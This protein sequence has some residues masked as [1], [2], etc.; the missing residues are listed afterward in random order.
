MVVHA[1][2]PL[3]ETRVQREAQALIARGFEVDV[4]CLRYPGEPPNDVHDGVNVYRVPVR[5]HNSAGMFRQLLE[6]LSF[7]FLASLKLA[8]LHFRRRY[9]VIQVHN[10]PDFL[11]FAS[12]IPK[13]AGARLILDLHDLMPEFYA[14][15]FHKTMDSWQLRLVRWQERVSCRFADHVI[16]VS[17]HWRKTLILRGVAPQKCSVVMNVAD[18]A[19][20]HL[21]EDDADSLPQDG[22]LRMVYHGIIVERYGLDLALQAIDKVRH[23]IPGIHLTIIGAGTFRRSIAQM[24]E[25]LDLSSHVRLEGFRPAE[26]LPSIIRTANLGIVPYRNDIFTDTLVPT[27]L[28]EYAALGM[29]AIAA[30]TTAIQSLFQGTMVEF[31]E[32]GDVEDLVRCM[33]L[34]HR[35]PERLAALAR[36]SQ[37]FN[38]RYNWQKTSSQYVDLVEQLASQGTRTTK[39]V[40]SR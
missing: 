26:K 7:F 25:E 10:L 35:V 40:V 31:F 19:V 8:Y 22:E 33:R 21:P 14:A 36:A 6:Y 4:I 39:R 16:T 32:P 20:F 23:D 11:I 37:E 13:L 5:R 1:Y 17:E 30:R 3:G 24:V 29:P 34:L 15:R 38:Q 27:K 18:P 28:M 2:Y 9:D 12:L